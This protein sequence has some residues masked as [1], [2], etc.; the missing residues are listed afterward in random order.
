MKKRKKALNTALERAESQLSEC[1]KK[2]VADHFG[3]LDKYLIGRIE[4]AIY[5][6][7]NK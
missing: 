2:Y 6:L 1:S 7:K 4:A 5:D 3:Y